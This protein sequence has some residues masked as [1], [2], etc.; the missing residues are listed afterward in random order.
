MTLPEAIELA[1][2]RARQADQFAAIAREATARFEEAS[3]QIVRLVAF[4]Q[5]LAEENA[6]LRTLALAEA[7]RG[8]LVN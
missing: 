7:E 5:G 1:S 8:G 6:R 2:Y 3:A 4:M